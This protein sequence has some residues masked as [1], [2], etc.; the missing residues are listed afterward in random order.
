MCVK[1]SYEIRKKEYRLADFFHMHWSKYTKSPKRYIK[2]E[3]YKA[4]NAIMVCRTAVLGVD[5]YACE[6]CGEVSEIYHSCNNRFCPTCSWKDTVD[7]AERTKYNMLNIKHRHVVCTVPHSLI[8]LIEANDNKLYSMLM[9]VSALTFKDWFLAKHNLKIGVIEVLHTYGEQKEMHP[10]THMIVSWG[11]IDKGSGELKEIESEYVKYGFLRKK[12]RAKFEDELIKMFD[13]EEL[14]HDF[15]NRMTFMQFVKSINK[16][17]WVVHL[18]PAMKTPSSVIRYIGRYSK[19]ACLSEYKITDI[20]GE[21]ISFRYKD[22]KDRDEEK[23]PK[24]K[25]LE[26]HY[27]DF[28]QD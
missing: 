26:L 16:T 27:T 1:K 19:R 12:F 24:E 9:R 28:F 3:Q 7:W 8:P 6:E 25:I 18:E 15:K 17:D 11:G 20:S 2:E 5:V 4:A 14:I 21:Y 23:K 13:N 22:Y 10:H